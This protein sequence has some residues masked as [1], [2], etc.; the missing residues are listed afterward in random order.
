MSWSIISTSL[1]E[2]ASGRNLS[3]EFKWLNDN[4]ILACPID[5]AEVV[6]V[7]LD[8]LDVLHFSLH[9]CWRDGKMARFVQD[10]AQSLRI[11]LGNDDF[12]SECRLTENE[13]LRL[14]SS[15]L[16]TGDLFANDSKFKRIE[17]NMLGQCLAYKNEW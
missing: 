11:S 2:A 12:L 6:E 8:R 17:T 13:T 4:G 7:D 10:P 15:R 16:L 9:D 3:V 14:S 5:L 1:F